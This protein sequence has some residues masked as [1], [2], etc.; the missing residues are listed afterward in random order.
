MKLKVT[1]NGQ[2]YTAAA[3]PAKVK[4]QKAPKTTAESKAK[5]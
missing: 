4:G 5:S 2:A 1:V 3:A